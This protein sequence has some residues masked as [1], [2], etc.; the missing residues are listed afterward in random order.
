MTLHYSLV[1]DDSLRIEVLE[2]L[3]PSN[4]SFVAI[5]TLITTDADKKYHGYGKT[6]LAAINDCL[7]KIKN[8]SIKGGLFLHTKDT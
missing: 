4:A 1:S 3:T 7:A 5:P 6:E 8:V 2:I